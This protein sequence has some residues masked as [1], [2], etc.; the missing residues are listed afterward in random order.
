MNLKQLISTMALAAA[1]LSG[2]AQADSVYS[3][4]DD[5]TEG[6]TS[7]GNPDTTSYGQ[8]FTAPGGILKAF[9]FQAWSGFGGNV[10]LVIA[11]W[12]GSKAVGPALYRSA[13][14]YYDGGSQF[15]GANGIDLALNAGSDYIA[16]LTL[17]GLTSPF[18]NVTIAGSQTDTGLGGGFRFLNSALVDPLTL[19]ESWSDWS[20]PHMAYSAT[21]AAAVPEPGT[22]AMLLVGMGMVG[23]MARRRK[24]QA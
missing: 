9:S 19:N 15:L 5:G 23:V 3:N 18:D 24:S 21:F 22:Y 16:Y 7:M 2:A 11:N 4:A 6:I 13:P 10:A 8:F 14:I 20:T 12:D 17:S 1:T